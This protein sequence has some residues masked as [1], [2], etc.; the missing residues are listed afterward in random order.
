MLVRRRQPFAE[1]FE[2]CAYEQAGHERPRD[3]QVLT[4]DGRPIALTQDTCGKQETSSC[5]VIH[6]KF[7]R[8]IRKLQHGVRV[9]ARFRAEEEDPE[10][11]RNRRLGEKG[12]VR[13]RRE[14]RADCTTAANCSLES[15]RFGSVLQLPP[16][17]TGL[18]SQCRAA[19]Q[20]IGRCPA[21]WICRSSCCPHSLRCDQFHDQIA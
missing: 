20:P 19:R 2:R 18:T 11:D 16:N 1:Q 17:A 14:E 3:C 10:C 4:S 6:R 8:P 21:E 15:P 7:E 9:E 5:P 12:H 13:P